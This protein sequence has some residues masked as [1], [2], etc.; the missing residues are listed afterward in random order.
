M[1]L[2]SL[3]NENPPISVFHSLD[4]LSSTW[5]SHTPRG[6]RKKKWKKNKEREEKRKKN[7]IELQTEPSW[8]EDSLD[9]SFL[10]GLRRA[11]H[12]LSGD[13][14]GQTT[15]HQTPLSHLAQE[16]LGILRASQ[17]CKH[18][19]ILWGITAKC[20]FLCIP[21][22]KSL[23]PINLLLI[24]WQTRPSCPLSDGQGCPGPSLGTGHAQGHRIAPPWLLQQPLP[25]LCALKASLLT[26]T[27]SSP[28]PGISLQLFALMFFLPVLLNLPSDN[29]KQGH[30]Q[31]LTQNVTKSRI[32]S[33][34]LYVLYRNI[35]TFSYGM[36]AHEFPSPKPRTK[37]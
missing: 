17:S 34:F 31:E 26:Q 22:D 6:K 14:D 32:S 12:R 30:S 7:P 10:P 33:L 27:Y 18:L 37:H 29:P 11:R 1:R 35:N 2:I 19:L 20:A 28:C 13:K 36:L 9:P 8:E 15:V 25:S 24:F 16:V 4:P 21:P 3:N 5:K 23:F